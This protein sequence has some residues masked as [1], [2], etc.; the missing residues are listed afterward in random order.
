MPS[1]N[2]T[3]PPVARRRGFT[4]FSFE[5]GQID[6]AQTELRKFLHRHVDGKI[7]RRKQRGGSNE[8]GDADQ[9]FDEH[10]AIADGARVRFLVDHLR[11]GAGTDERV[12]A[13]NG[14]AGNGDENE[15][16][17]LAGDDG[18]AAGNVF[19]K[20]GHFQIRM[21]HDDAED[22]KCDGADFHV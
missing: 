9:A 4:H 15:R 14:A 11:R 20:R 17:E 19:S 6:H 5:L 2:D 8:R 13:G 16:I 22:E 21:H 3:A 7:I 1:A 10:G 12:K 18:P